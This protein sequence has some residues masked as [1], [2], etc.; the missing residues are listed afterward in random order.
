MGLFNP[1]TL[2]WLWST[3][4]AEAA[5]H[6]KILISSASITSEDPSTN[7]EKTNC[8]TKSL[9][10]NNFIHLPKLCIQL[11]ACCLYYSWMTSNGS[12][13]T[14]ICM[15]AIWLGRVSSVLS[16]QLVIEYG[17]YLIIWKGPNLWVYYYYYYLKFWWTL[18][19]SQKNKSLAAATEGMLP[20]TLG[21]SFTEW[22]YTAGP[23]NVP[24]IFLLPQLWKLMHN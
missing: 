9:P 14:K 5:W 12:T 8:C 3:R 11:I 20:C 24:L 19:N 7:L 23:K 4:S 13:Q 22:L 2:Q 10:I 6:T 16:L 17:S 21:Q 15:F 1:L 18:F